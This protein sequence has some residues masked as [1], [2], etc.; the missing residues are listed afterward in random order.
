MPRRHA[1]QRRTTQGPRTVDLRGAQGGGRPHPTDHH[2][3]VARVGDQPGR[4]SGGS[5][6]ERAK[7]RFVASEPP[8]QSGP[9]PSERSTRPPKI[10]RGDNQRRVTATTLVAGTDSTYEVVGNV[11]VDDTASAARRA[12]CLECACKSPRRRIAARTR[13]STTRCNG[14]GALLT[15]AQPGWLFFDNAVAPS[16]SALTLE[17]VPAS[18]ADSSVGSADC[19]ALDRHPSRSRFVVQAAAS[20]RHAHGGAPGEL[21]R[22]DARHAQDSVPPAGSDLVLEGCVNAAPATECEAYASLTRGACE[23]FLCPDCAFRH[24]CDESCGYCQTGRGSPPRNSPRI[25]P[26]R[27]SRRSRRQ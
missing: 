19:L 26:R 6:P 25:S 10:V 15:N 8:P 24:S 7:V 11:A 18:C 9:K 1:V 4:R 12:R 21:R 5:R 14:F 3:A 16:A 22:R 17:K 27:I 13:W 2:L 23:A 20:R